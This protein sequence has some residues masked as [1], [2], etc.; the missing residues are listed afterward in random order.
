MKVNFKAMSKRI[1]P[2]L[3]RRS[4]KGNI[5]SVI[6]GTAVLLSLTLPAF[7]K[8]YST[9]TSYISATEY[10]YTLASTGVG[11]FIVS[12]SIIF[13]AVAATA[14][15]LLPSSII[16][17][18]LAAAV[19]AADSAA[20]WTLHLPLSLIGFGIWILYAGLAAM[21]AGCIVKR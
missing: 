8:I 2:F 10:V 17:C 20:L 5:I 7:L 11:S 4:A 9:S 18:S 16:T 6:G 14:A 13:T 19:I 1:I 21:I 12:A 15:V 3:A